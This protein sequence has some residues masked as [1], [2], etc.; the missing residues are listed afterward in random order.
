MSQIFIE[1]CILFLFNRFQSIA[2]LWSFLFSFLI[3]Y[4]IDSI[5]EEPIYGWM[6]FFDLLL[7]IKLFCC[8]SKAILI[9]Y[10]AMILGLSDNS[11]SRS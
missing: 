3:N 4:D 8:V 5:L 1:N 2:N 6:C 7:Q 9:G 11:Y 10:F